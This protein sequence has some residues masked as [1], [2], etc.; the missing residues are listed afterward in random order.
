V[1]GVSLHLFAYHCGYTQRVAR[2][3]LSKEETMP[4]NTSA[5]ED[6]ALTELFV[7]Q[8]DAE[9]VG[10][11]VKDSIDITGDTILDWIAGQFSPEEV[12]D[13]SDL[14]NWASQNGF[15]KERE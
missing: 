9:Q 7:N 3:P 1:P 5:G 12:F 4:R 10:V 11:A 13:E 2:H 14:E 6:Y 15:V 8:L